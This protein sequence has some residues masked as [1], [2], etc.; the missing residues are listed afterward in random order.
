MSIRGE[1]ARHD[2]VSPASRRHRLEKRAGLPGKH[3]TCFRCGHD[4]DISCRNNQLQIMVQQEKLVFE[5]MG[6]AINCQL[7]IVK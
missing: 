7:S 6:L 2:S 5:R 1:E 4:T 3:W